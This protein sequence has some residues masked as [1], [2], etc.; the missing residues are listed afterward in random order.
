MSEQQNNDFDFLDVSLSPDDSIETILEK[1]ALSTSSNKKNAAASK[2]KNEAETLEKAEMVVE[3]E[4]QVDKTEEA[5]IEEIKAVPEAENVEETDAFDDISFEIEE[6]ISTEHLSRETKAP[7]KRRFARFVENIKHMAHSEGITDI[8]AIFSKV[9]FTIY[10]L[11]GQFFTWFGRV[12]RYLL[13]PI[14]AG[15]V[16]FVIVVFAGCKIAVKVSMGEDVIGYVNSSDEYYEAQTEAETNISIKMGEEFKV[17]TVPKYSVAIVS[18]SDVIEGEELVNTVQGYTEEVIGRNFGLFVDGNLIG[19]NRKK[20][21]IEEMLN[22]IKSPYSSG[23]INETVSFA[24]DVQVIEGEY[25]ETFA[26]TVS[27][28]REK[29]MRSSV[30]SQYE[31]TAEDTYES[32]LV[33]FSMTEDI[34]ALLNPS[35]NIDE[36]AEGDMINI[37]EIKSLITV[38]VERVVSY[39]N[40]IP[41]ESD[42]SYDPNVWNSVKTI[43]TPGETGTSSVVANLVYLNGIEV[44]R[45]IISEVVT[46]EPVTEVIIQGTKVISASGSFTWPLNDG[47]YFLITDRF[48]EWRYDHNHAALDIAGFYGTPI[49]VCDSG[50]VIEAGWGDSYG[51]YILVQHSDRCCTRYAH[52]SAIEVNVGDEV[53]QGQEI[54]LMGSTGYSTGTHLHL[55]VLIDGE[56]CNPEDFVHI[57]GE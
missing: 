55:E 30:V 11:L 8:G 17:D 47:D 10:E 9:A 56:K 49:L 54:G 7:R 21:A 23:E 43:V 50:E 34:F 29:L 40:S 46:K 28:M 37:S 15:M 45:Q 57:P 52:L 27:E 44:E 2:P 31:V 41:Y 36:M 6:N 24:Q 20:A 16:V 3:S 42:I 13:L 35:L 33:K 22:S 26:M 48:D 4:V 1:F 14:A 32:L 39:E 25:D 12:S 5:V 51:Y 19:T 18:R 38:K 53:Y